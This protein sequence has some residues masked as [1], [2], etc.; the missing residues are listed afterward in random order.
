VDEGGGARISKIKDRIIFEH[1]VA[2]KHKSFSFVE[3]GGGDK[4]YAM[5]GYMTWTS[6]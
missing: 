5:S 4:L 1:H 2:K 6:A 3:E